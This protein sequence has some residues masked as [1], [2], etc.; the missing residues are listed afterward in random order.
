MDVIWINGWP[1]EEVRIAGG[2]YLYLERKGW[3]PYKKTVF[4]FDDAH[5]SY[6]CRELWND[7]FK[8]IH[9]Y[10]N[11]RAIAFTS[12][13]SPMLWV[14]EQGT[15]L[16]WCAA[17]TVLLRPVR[18]NDYLPPVGLLFSRGEFDDLIARS[19]PNPKYYF[20]SSFFDSVFSLTGGH[21]GAVL[22]F[23]TAITSHDVCFLYWA[24]VAI[25]T[26]HQSYCELKYSGQLYTWDTFS[27]K[28]SLPDLF[29]RL[30]TS[31]VQKGLPNDKD[32]Q[33][34]SIAHIF[35]TVLD[36][37][38]VIKDDFTSEDDQHAL[39]HCFLNGWLQAH[40]LCE[41]G[42]PEVV[43]FGFASPL[44]RWFVEWKLYSESSAIQSK[45][46]GLS[47]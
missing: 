13:G 43:T 20:D 22:G 17:Q 32:L 19:Y 24:E 21:V 27:E 4:I 34:L 29:E 3:E 25:L 23:I 2:A 11:R 12:F 46:T 28:V 30:S 41:I 44:H 10:E 8:T 9:A 16:E 15:P 47:I 35:S 1:L 40:T 18:H 26:L 37:G 33:T 31:A 38:I 5:M 42:P 14:F 39:Q 45:F 6:M 36:Q 7:F